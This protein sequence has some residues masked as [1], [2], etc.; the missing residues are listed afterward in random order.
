MFIDTK[1]PWKSI[2]IIF[3]YLIVI[4]KKNT[5]NKLHK[6][7]CIAQF[8]NTHNYY[9]KAAAWTNIYIFILFY[10]SARKRR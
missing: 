9:Y 8:S 10:Q 5:K 4:T 1:K 2:K 3:S 6:H 7:T